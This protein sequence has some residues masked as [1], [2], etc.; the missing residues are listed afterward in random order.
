[1]VY[2]LHRFLNVEGEVP[3]HQLAKMPVGT[4]AETGRFSQPDAAGAIHR[5]VCIAP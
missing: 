3:R 1:M 5:V 4:V 2:P